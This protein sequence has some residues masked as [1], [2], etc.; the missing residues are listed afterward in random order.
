L[1]DH[2]SRKL[3][4]NNNNVDD[5]II[6][7]M[8]FRDTELNYGWSFSNTIY[9]KIKNKR[10]HTVS[11]SNFMDFSMKFNINQLDIEKINITSW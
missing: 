11:N 2:K 9:D 4:W 1:S 5:I 7:L 3:Q 8:I 6:I 10:Y